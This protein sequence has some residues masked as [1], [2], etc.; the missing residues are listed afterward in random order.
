MFT[1]SSEDAKD[2]RR[3][4]ACAAEPVRYVGVELGDLAGAEHPVLVAEDEAHVAGEDVD[5]FVAVVRPRLRVDFAGGDD[6]LSGLEGVELPGQRYHR[7]TFHV[8]RSEPV[9]G[10]PTP[11]APTRSSSGT[12]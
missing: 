7:P 3:F 4:V 6:D 5:P 2:L 10:S 1:G 11:G 9:R 8:A 12:Q